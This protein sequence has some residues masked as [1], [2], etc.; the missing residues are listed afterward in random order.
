MEEKKRFKVKTFT[1]ELRIF[2]T[3]KELKG[4]DEEVNHFIA[5]NRV[6][7]VISVSDTTTTDDT[8]ATI[9]MIRVLT[10]ET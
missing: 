1:T 9:G 6:K 4:L 10:Y 3:I 5:K 7:K 2:K 8:G